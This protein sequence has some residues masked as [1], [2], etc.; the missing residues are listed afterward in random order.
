MSEYNNSNLKA[1]C[2]IKIIAGSNITVNLGKMA[3]SLI[4]GSFAKDTG[5]V[6][7]LGSNSASNV[8]LVTTSADI[9]CAGAVSVY[10]KDLAPNVTD[11]SSLI[12]C[13]TA[14]LKDP[15]YLK[16]IGFD[17]YGQVVT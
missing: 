5:T 2:N 7:T 1:N 10:N 12:G 14:Q 15:A 8:I 6:L 3:Y 16:S 11:T 17:I 4:Q 13:T 9:S